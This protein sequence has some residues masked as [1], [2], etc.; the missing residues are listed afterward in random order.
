MAL[1]TVAGKVVKKVVATVEQMGALTVEQME[2]KR[3]VQTVVMMVAL[4]AL[5]KAAMT[6][7]PEEE[8]L[9]IHELIDNNIVGG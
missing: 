1:W 8:E 2:K 6:V 4:R 7:V 3:A 9:Y 5:Q